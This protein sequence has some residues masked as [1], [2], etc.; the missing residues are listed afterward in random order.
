[1]S[2][3]SSGSTNELSKKKEQAL[4][5][6]CLDTGFLL[7]SFFDPGDGGDTFLWNVS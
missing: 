3:P 6:T 7:M 2:P 4:L 1:M 5:A